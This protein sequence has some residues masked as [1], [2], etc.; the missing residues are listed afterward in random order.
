MKYFSILILSL[1]FSSSAIAIPDIKEV[2]G[3]EVEILVFKN[4]QLDEQDNEL[5]IQ[6]ISPDGQLDL[7]NVTAVGGGIPA[8]SEI[9]KAFDKMLASGNYL[10]ITHKRWIQDAIPKTE[11][12]LIRITNAETKL[13]GTVHFY[14]N[15]FLHLDINLM[16]GEEFVPASSNDTLAS[17]DA[18]K[19]TKNNFVIKEKRRIRSENINYFDHPRFGVLVQVNK[20]ILSTH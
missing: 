19:N 8:D 7:E 6:D 20:I 12:Q 13:D 16:L 15:R 5:W 2:P 4:L 1:L 10:L 3:Y 11:A 9:R 18:Q 14:K 17:A